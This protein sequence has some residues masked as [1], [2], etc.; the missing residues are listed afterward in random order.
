M[1]DNFRWWQVSADDGSVGWV[2]DQV[3]DQ[4]GTTNTLAPQ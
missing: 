1:V 4:D 3:T 2:V